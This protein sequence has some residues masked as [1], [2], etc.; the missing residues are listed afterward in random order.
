MVCSKSRGRV[1]P[2]LCWYHQSCLHLNLN[3]SSNQILGVE[4]S[5][6]WNPVILLK[7]NQTLKQQFYND[8]GRASFIFHHHITCVIKISPRSEIA[9][10]NH[11]ETSLSQMMDTCPR[12]ILQRKE[13]FS[14]DQQ[15]S[16]LIS[17]ENVVAVCDMIMGKEMRK[18]KRG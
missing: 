16:Y 14:Y 3:V 8:N 15:I 5:T 4:T 10:Y 6:K 17:L 2:L 13:R 18:M 11:I 9:I 12:R 7:A 1:L